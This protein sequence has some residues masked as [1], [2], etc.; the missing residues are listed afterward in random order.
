MIFETH[1]HYDDDRF[2]D[3]RDETIKRVHEKGVAPIINVGASIGSTM[4]TIELAKKYDFIYA[5]VGVHPSDIADLNEETFAWLREQTAWERTVAVGEIGLDYY[6]DKEPNVQENQ[7]YWFKRQLELAAEASLPVIIHSRDAAQDTMEIMTEAAKKNIRG[8]IH[9]YSYSPEMALEYVK[10]G[11]YIGVGG[12]VTFKN[13]KKLVQTVS[14]LPLDR[15]LLETDCPYMAPEPHRGTRNDSSNI[16]Y[17]IKKIAEIK[18]TTPFHLMRQSNC[19]LYFLYYHMKCLYFNY[20]REFSRF[21][22]KPGTKS[23]NRRPAI[24]HV[25]FLVSYASQLRFCTDYV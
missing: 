5:A 9:C 6:W 21:C 16:P 12:V 3:D 20:I 11:Y 25:H 4:T 1:A 8:V 24:G 19:C 22:R 18:G 15:I 7:R 2:K 23:M 10:L 17:V 13:A 14:E